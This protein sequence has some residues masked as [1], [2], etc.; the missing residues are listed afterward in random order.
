VE[1]AQQTRATIWR[2]DMEHGGSIKIPAGARLLSC[3]WRDGGIKLWALCDPEVPK[4]ERRVHMVS[5]G[6]DI[7]DAWEFCGTV[8]HG[9]NEVWHVFLETV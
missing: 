1:P 3:A 7:A 4:V 6:H 9:P 5:T 2:F 8:L